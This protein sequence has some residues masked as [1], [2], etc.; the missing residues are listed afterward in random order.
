M[1][2]FQSSGKQ[3]IDVADL[4]EMYKK[5]VVQYPS[6]ALYLHEFKG[7]CRVLDT[8]EE[9][10][11]M[12]NIFKTFD[13]NGDNVID[14]LEYVAALNLVLRGKLEHKL[15]WSF[16][17]YD[18]DGNG[19][20]DKEELREII[21]VIYNI[22]TGSKLDHE[23]QL[24]TPDEVCDRIFKIVDVNGD[25]AQ[26]IPCGSGIRE[27]SQAL[28][29]APD[30]QEGMNH[31]SMADAS[32]QLAQTEQL[33]VQLKELI[34]EKDH[35]LRTKDEQIK[36]EKEACEAKLSKVKLQN[37]AKVNSLN[38]QLEE[39]KKQLTPSGT[40]EERA[41]LK[42]ATGDGN[43]E[44]A[45]ASRGKILL[46]KKKVEE[47]ETQLS[48][49]KAE[50]KNK[51]A[52]IET[53]R[54]R[55]FEIDAMLAEKDKKLSEKEAYIIDLQLIASGE[56]PA[57]ALSTH[58]E[59]P[60]VQLTEKEIPLQDLQMLVKN[61]TKKVEESEEKYSLLKEQSESL[62]ELLVTE[63]KQFEGKENMYKENIQTFKDIIME[64]E[65]NLVEQYQK[66]EHELFKLAAKSD[67]SA[68]LEQ[69]LKALKQKLHEKEEVL[70]G[71]TQVVDVLQTEL[72]TRDQQIKE[73]SEKM[74]R[75]Q[76]EKDSMQ[77]K[78]DAEKHVM[79]AQL[80]D[81][82]QKHE[83]ELKHVREKHETELSE[84]DQAYLQLQKQL[85]EVRNHTEAAGALAMDSAVDA[86]SNPRIVALEVQAKL[87]TEEAS[88]SEAKFLKMK[89]WSKSRI[90]QL[91]DE[92]KKAQSGTTSSDITALR[93]RLVE[94]EDEREE[95][96]QK[97]EQYEELKTLNA[98][99]V[100]KL[101]IYE[102]QQRKMQADL[103]Q[104]TKRAASRTSESGS[105]DELQ[106]HVLKWQD[107]VSDAEGV[108]DQAREE[109][110]AM[111]LR[112]THLEEEREVLVTRQQELEEELAQA[113]GL[114]AKRGKQKQ[115]ANITH[116]LQEDFEFD[117]KQSYQ[118]PNNTLDSSD[119]A[120]G[121]NMGGLRSVVEE[122]ELERNQLQEQILTL[123]EQCQHL[124]DRLQ[125][126]AR[127]ES[128]Q[129]EN[130]RL[131]GQLTNLRSQ[132]SRDTEKHQVLISSLNQ[133]LKGFSDR[134]EILESSLIEKEQT[135]METSEKLEQI[136][137][138]RDSLKEK[139]V[140]N[141]E[142]NDKL[143]QAE[144]NVS[145]VTGKC[146]TYEKQCS[147]LKTSVADLTHRLNTAKEK[148]QK[149]DVAI[150][151]LQRDLDQ[152]NDEL[153]KLN[154]S[155]LEERAQ[156]IH[157]LQSCERE[158][159]SLKDVLLQKDK[160][161]TAL[162]NSMTEY[163]DQVLQL[164]QQMK[165][166][167]EEM[168]GM[169]TALAKVERQAQIIR[170]SQS[171]DEQTMNTKLASLV[172]QL[173]EME[174]EL[175]NTREENKAKCSEVEE[176]V[177]QVHDDNGI[178]QN[179]RTDIQKLKHIMIWKDLFSDRE[180]IL[181]SSLIEKEQTLMETSEKLEQIENIRDSLKEKEVQNKELND[182]LLQAEQNVS[183]VTGKCC[184]YEKQC[185]ELKTSVADLTHR[186]NTAKEKTQKQDVAIEIL[187]RDLD[188]TN[189]ELDKLNSS[190]L[191]ERAQL[192]HDLQSC[193]REIDSLKDVLLQ[194]DKEITALSN[195]MTEYLD[196]VLQLKQQMK[197][198][199][200]EMVGMETAL[201]KVERQAQIIR[202]SQSSDE[203]TMNTKLA[204]LVEQ[205]KEMEMELS[206]TR[207]ENKAKCS[208]VEELVK[209]VHDD[210]GIIQNLRTDIQKLNVT[211]RTHLAECETQLSSLKEQVT[212]SSRRLQEVDA[213]SLEETN[214]LAA[215]LEETNTAYK[216]LENM[217]Q[218]KEQSFET[219]L[220]SF[221]DEC[222]KLIAEVTRKDEEL[223]IFSKQLAEHVEHQ[224]TGKRAVH[225]KLETISCLEGKL[226]ATQQE[227]E[228]TKLKLNQK[229]Q[230]KETECIQLKEQ[231]EVKS[232]S[233][234]KLETEVKT[235]E[236]KNE[237]LQTIVQKKDNEILVQTNLA[238][239]LNEKVANVQGAN[240]NLQCK[241][242]QLTDESEKLKRKLTDQ[243]SLQSKQHDLVSELQG[244]IS[245]NEV[246]ISEYQ[247]TVAVMQ[248]EKEEL[249][250]KTEDLVK[251]LEQNQNVVAENLVDKTSECNNLAKLLSEN[252]ESIAHLQD[253]VQ[254]LTSQID[255]LKC[256]IAE[257]EQAV[258]DRVNTCENLQSQLG[259]LQETLPMLQEQNHA[260]QLGLVEK[261]LILQEKV[262]ECHSLQKQINQQ[263]ES[264][265]NLQ[266]EVDSLK[267]EGKKLTQ[268]L[269]E[270]E[271]AFQS[272]ICECNELFDQIQS[273]NEAIAV[274]SRQIDVMNEESVKL[275]SEN[276]DLKTTLNNRNVDYSK[277]HE[278]ATLSKT[279]AAE[280]QSQVQILNAEIQDTKTDILGKLNE[281][282]VLQSELSKK[283][284]TIVLLNKQLQTKYVEQ[285]GQLSENMAVIAQLQTQGQDMQKAL[286]QKENTLNMQ[287]K[288]IKQLKDKAEESEMLKSQL[289]EYLEMISDLQ[290]QLKSMTER[291]D[292]LKCSMTEK[293]AVLKKK[294]DD[295][296]SLKAQFCD[297]E[298]TASQL[299]VQ[300]EQV[301]TELHTVKDT[302]KE[303][304]LNLKQIEESSLVQRE[305]LI[306]KY[307]DK[308][309]EC[310]SLKDELSALQETASGLN[311]HITTQSS[312]INQLK[313][314]VLKTETGI[315]E[316]NK[317]MQELQEQVEEAKLFKSQLMESTELI[318]QLQR[319]LQK[320]TSES[321]MLDKSA[322]EKQTAFF[323]LQERYAAQTEQ[324]QEIKSALAQKNEEISSL[325]R[326][327][328]EKG[329]I[330]KVAEN[331]SSTLKIEV[332]QLKVEL[333]KNKVSY[334]DLQQKENALAAEI[335][336]QKA[337]NLEAVKQLNIAN[338]AVEQ[339]ELVV[340]SLNSKYAEQLQNIERLNSEIL[341]LNE[342]NSDMKKEM[343]LMAQ[344]LQQKLDSAVREKLVLKQDI[345]RTI[346]EKEELIKNYSDQLQKKKDE[347]QTL[348]QLVANLNEA[349]ERLKNEK[350][351]LQMQV[352]AKGEE[353]TG[354]K[355]EIQKIEQTLMDSENEWLADL[356]RDNQKSSLLTEQLRSL[357]NEMNSKD[358]KIQA[359]QQDLDNMQGKF[360]E[361][362]SALKMSSDE[363]TEKNM[364][365]AD[366]SQHIT[367]NQNKLE[368]MCL[369]V[370][371]KD[372]VVQH[373]LSEREKE[374]KNLQTE[375]LTSQHDLSEISQS[376]SEKLLAFEEEKFT[377]Q[378]AMKQ[379]K[380]RHQSEVESLKQELDRNT[381]VL[382]QK[383]SEMSEKDK[384][385]Q[386]EKKQVRLLQQQVMNLQQELAIS[387]DKLSSIVNDVHIKE[388]Q[389]QSLTLQVNQ[390][391]E[392]LTSINQ[393]LREKNLSVTRVMES[394][395]NEIVK[396]TE[397]KNQLIVQIENLE[398]KHSCSTKEIESLYQQLDEYKSTLSHS[399]A[400]VQ[401]K[402]VEKQ[403][404]INE[405]E[406]L[407]VHHDKLAKEKDIMKR[408]F[409][410]ALLVRKELMKKIEELEKKSQDDLNKDKETANL[411]N[412]VQ[413]LTSQVTQAQTRCKEQ[414]S[415]L[416][417]LK[418]QILQKEADINEFVQSLST[419]ET[420]VGQ[421]ED[422]IQRLETT[423]LERETSLADALKA[424]MEKD[425]VIEA[426]QCSSKE[427]EKFFHNERCELTSMLGQLRDELLKKEEPIKV[428][429]TIP[430][431]TVVDQ[432]SNLEAATQN[433]K[434]LEQEKE[435]LQKKLHAALLAR[436]EAIKKAQEKERNLRAE[437]IQQKEEFD[438]L[439]T[440]FSQQAEELKTTKEKLTT[441]QQDYCGKL[442]EFENN[443]QVIGALQ[444][445]LN[446]INAH[447]EEKEKSLQEVKMQLEE[448][449][450][451][452][453]SA[454]HDQ[455]IKMS[456]VTSELE[457]KANSQKALED[458]S[459][460]LAR[461]IEQLRSEI[462]RANI[463]ITE[464]TEELLSLQRTV[465]IAQQ[466]HQ[467]EKQVLIDECTELQNQLTKTQSDVEY[468][469]ISLE[470]IKKEK[471]SQSEAFNNSNKVLLEANNELKEELEKVH[472]LI[473]EKSD[474]CKAMKNTLA[475]MQ[476]QFE[477]EKMGIKAKSEQM[478]SCW[479][480]AQAKA[481]SYKLHLEKIEKEKEDIFCSLEKSRGVSVTLQEQLDKSNR[482]KE[483]LAEK[484]YLLQEEISAATQHEEKVF[485]LQ[486][487]NEKLQ[488]ILEEKENAIVSLKSSISE[489]EE[490]LAALELQMQKALHLHE[491]ERG[492]VKTEMHELHQKA[493][494][495]S[496]VSKEQSDVSKSNEQITR[497]LQAALISRKEALK[498][499]K[500]LKD[501]IQTLYSEKEELIRM[502]SSLE[503]SL[504]DMKNQ[505]EDLKVSIAAISDEKEILISE[506]DKILSDNHSL[507]AACESLKHTIENITQQKQAFS[508]QLESLKDSE[509]EEL[510]EWKSKHKE[511]KQEYES[512]LQA[513]ENISSEMDKMRQL[514]ET[515]RK[516]K[517]EVLSKRCNL[518][519]EKEVLEKQLNEAEEEQEKQKEKMRT[520]AKL[521]QQ[522]IQ[523]LEEENG[524][525]KNDQ[526]EM[527]EKQQ[528][529]VEELAVKKI[530]LEEENKE[531]QETCE[532]LRVKLN[533]IQSEKSSLLS[534]VEA[535]RSSLEKLQAET[536]ASQSDLQIK[537]N[538]ALSLKD[539]LAAELES[540]KAD[541][542]AKVEVIKTLEQE[543]LSL[544]EQVTELERQHKVELNKRDNTLA[545]LDS[546]INSNLR[547][548]ISL[549]EKVRI[550][551]DDKS[552]LQ[553]ELENVQEISEK[554]KNENEYLET[555][556]LKSAERIDLLTD[557]VNTLQ[558]QNNLLSTQLSEIK[559]EKYGLIREKEGQQVKLVRDF[560]E[561]LKVA[562]RG[563]EGSKSVT[564]ELQEL[565]REKHQEINQMQKDCIQYQELI[566]DLERSVKLSQSERDA[567][568]KEL[569]NV[570][571]KV[572]K[573]D[574]EI[575][576]LYNEITSYKDLLS[577]ARKQSERV[578]SENARLKEELVQKEAQA[579]LQ[580]MDRKKELEQVNEQQ[581]A[582]YKNE[583]MKV[584]ERINVLQREKERNREEVLQLKSE[585]ESRDLLT[586]ILEKEA[587]T[588]LAKLAAFSRTISSLQNDGDSVADETKQW[589]L[590]FQEVIEDKEKQLLDQKL[591]VL[592][593]TE[594]MKIKD[595]QIHEFQHKSSKLEVAFDETDSRYKA[596]YVDFQNEKTLLIATSRELSR[597]F[598]MLKER[599]EEQRDHVQ[600][601]EE[602]KKVLQHQL[603]DTG[604]A[605]VQMKAELLT[606]EKRFTD[607]D[608]ELQLIQSLSD[609]L[610]VDL[611]KQEAISMQLKSLLINKDTE[612]SML[613]SSK[614]GEISG[615]LA[616]IQNQNRIQIASYEERVNALYDDKEKTDKAFRGLENRIK[617]LQVKYEKSVQEKEQMAAKMGNLKNAL[618]SSQSERDGLL[619]EYKVLEE[620]YRSVA[621]EK[622]ILIQEKATE[623]K[624]L[625][626]EM[627]TL[628]HQMDDLNSENAML[629]A[630][631]IRY[632]EDLNQVLSLKDNQL[633]Q[634]LKKQ[635]D[636]IKNLEHGTAVVEKQYR[637]A[638][639][640]LE[641][642]IETIKSLE[643]E[644][645][646]LG[647][648]VCELEAVI[649]TMTKEKLEMNET[650][651]IADLQE[652]IAAKTTEC[653]ELKQ[654]LDAQKATTKELKIKVKKI[655]KDTDKIL[656][657]AEVKYNKELAAFEQDVDL[658]RNV[659]ERA[660]E[661]VVEISKDLM[662]A[663]QTIS[664]A[665]NLNK[666][667]K[668]QNESFG[669]AMAALQNDRDKLIEDFKHMQMKYEDELKT[670]SDKLN[671]LELQL[672]DATS[673]LNALVKER[674]VLIRTLSAFESDSTYNQLMVQIEDLRKAVA[675]RDIEIT[676]FSSEKETYSRQMTAFSKS[677]ASLQDDRDRLL[678]E[679]RGSKRVY[680]PR[681][682]TVSAASTVDSATDL[683][684]CAA[685]QAENNRLSYQIQIEHL[686]EQTISEAK[687][688]NKELK[689]Q[690]ESFGKAMAAL[691]NDRDKLI[692]DFKHM[693]MK[694][695]D[696]LKTSSDK[697][698]KLEL[699]LNDATSE[700]NALVKERTVLIRTLSAFE[701]DSTYNQ[702][703]VQIEDLR[704]A[705]ADRDIEIT[706]FSSEKET[707]SRQM[708]AFSKS[709]ASLQDDRDRLLQELR[710]S[711]RVYEPRQGTVSAASTV[712]SATDLNNCAALQAENNRL[713][714]EI[715]SLRSECM[716]LPQMKSKAAEL[717]KA[718]QQA[719]AFRLQTEQDVGAYQTELAELRTEKNL[720]L[721]ESRSLKEQYLIMVADKDRQISELQKLYPE[722]SRKSSGIYPIKTESVTLVANEDS[723]DQVKLLL[724]ERIQLQSD[725]QRCLQEIHHRDLCFQQLN[726]KMMQTIEEK[727]NLT[728]QLKAVAQTLRD[729]QLHHNELQNR[730]YWLERQLQS[731]PI[732]ASVQGHVQ[733]K[734]GALSVKRWLRGRSLY[735]SKLLTSRAKSRYLFLTY[736]LALHFAVFMCLTGIL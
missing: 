466:Q 227:A 142:L 687:N 136:E 413:E 493:A 515:T 551:E 580:K 120:D 246:H 457:N 282:A 507:S 706:R 530:E 684:N 509:T 473:A 591:A 123:E 586:K 446:Y 430:L 672:N 370:Q 513:Y 432:E 304:E 556:L 146:C 148:T 32:E 421:L 640:G 108:R 6:G 474:D 694:Y 38:S 138:I 159:D 389:I 299:R 26:L 145:E 595:M 137:N 596:A 659:S 555:V 157:D 540:Q 698:N 539:L 498:E 612:I 167:E 65:N 179:L 104:V 321:T 481:E 331:T 155:H 97:L 348:E 362:S 291:S 576:N 61:L 614:G 198:K 503:K 495:M 714:Q 545:K 440:E 404:L 128:L 414:D 135:L 121:E 349:G 514:V 74:K 83:T 106:S 392:L 258:I 529:T 170:E 67:A 736:L 563:N 226:K 639:C 708:T 508:C 666:E 162:S 537:I 201:A 604:D 330:I 549:N 103:E 335:E 200:E 374:I 686:A 476:H 35:I 23:T 149:Q 247:K 95:I 648:Q 264:V 388:G 183:E 88:K 16:K 3:E 186:L 105:A 236:N 154:S 315:L 471:D 18:K 630:Q 11:Y 497:K 486:S 114:R 641:Q 351:Q 363:L 221:K 116:N 425:A 382:Q 653:N 5:F 231:L 518:E 80:R 30:S 649:T 560:E 20:L 411:Q 625:K 93:N 239:D 656:S 48:Q 469:T 651:V 505:Q 526:L 424:G 215:Q 557:T 547:E 345:D 728:T 448:Q 723:S 468:F 735:C 593:L 165:Y 662:Q 99:L 109:K 25:G 643:S 260:L 461:E 302:V 285:E 19:C 352:S 68:E 682:G 692:E 205:L 50:L 677:M 339:R 21:E 705:V 417:L 318:Y 98:E 34:R 251:L 244:K 693:Q 256:N 27:T 265:V 188:Q 565:L 405:K 178:I 8:S 284:D 262:T 654:N 689:S 412:T 153:D 371:K 517:Q 721:T 605:V 276:E 676:R 429:E 568:E 550:L 309:D 313:E 645:E 86:G 364:V 695:E 203:Q 384:Y 587:N 45:A 415:H 171:S 111:A 660:E 658:M 385:I 92:L 427:N 72:N 378:A 125:L 365:V 176:L 502:S 433:L 311:E 192:I 102:E 579:D 383:V 621:N 175:S 33:V 163:L 458:D 569:K 435:L 523:E 444:S 127:I 465:N 245:A 55:G 431:S 69:L 730:C 401:S 483:E 172:E 629:K 206:N 376:M 381:E 51:N 173:K 219:E 272:R 623:S 716:E 450:N 482:L 675:D 168:V 292:H 287:Q 709:M 702:L 664:E 29:K 320:L 602:D 110:A 235:L 1:G 609:T 343:K 524:K 650:K 240:Q 633:K 408:K 420:L 665:K 336:V 278:Q 317:A 724:T 79:R 353:I 290:K 622:A 571:E 140:Q 187:Q 270:K 41:G 4:Q 534:D 308:Q 715:T 400:L 229:L 53:Q 242:N 717:Q 627:K 491:V 24:L 451:K 322:E 484:V 212:A 668:S 63:K 346:A 377:L 564:K 341:S 307:K 56:N 601:L 663:E 406:Q 732:Q 84:K 191:E 594:E 578:Q 334:A 671:K 156:L 608:S 82:M 356:D 590:K 293:E 402:D 180:E 372:S 325:H 492:R 528:Q 324:L 151:I 124:E 436:R 619:S 719:D 70:L 635:L 255:Q 644:N 373:I 463:K 700:L 541:I 399:Q 456:A 254:L 442:K 310:E 670:S 312:E 679:L 423:I 657:D 607:T 397:E 81:L 126:Q 177:K 519:T 439:L 338:Q 646:K 585:I 443:Q 39:L 357:E 129:N 626:Q 12:D 134:E 2:Q 588:N 566:L 36:M 637:D 726:G 283:E 75:L 725:L 37:K 64:K 600:K 647:I 329:D 438:K 241:V 669:K 452:M 355:L 234:L 516:E 158:I 688:L 266:N 218:K 499:N 90:K 562:Q 462:E 274:L 141:K 696:E 225:E 403:G 628:L 196:Q 316:Q 213:K 169:E 268:S 611:E 344:N 487:Q 642:K 132:H 390:Q 66:H 354:L 298:D 369:V 49:Y 577:E 512:L 281:I 209:Q 62:K 279:E 488:V 532:K 464:K 46:L 210:N 286:Q 379:L 47:L 703:M 489:K 680:E 731:R 263:N 133:Q 620:R 314:T 342:K 222:N 323:H 184:T 328:S 208:E 194:K 567:I 259:Q 416:E 729:T 296:V 699:Q 552:L 504:A 422:N 707:Y 734:G 350:E 570:N 613:L 223:L 117:G 426:L 204:S 542:V 237:Q 618:T 13:K 261:D 661:R 445:Q 152:T 441:I 367:E 544:S 360:A 197:Y 101:Q 573:F 543:K 395:S 60:K 467:Q 500:S 269:E 303:K 407:K 289:N 333:V 490:L 574:D 527:A 419:K 674:T 632:R 28:P 211:H 636:S 277:L 267:D 506:V 581:K 40:K 711:K 174:M 631:L 480:Q 459:K 691:Q 485:L 624:T 667:L 521:K 15:K 358:V 10:L 479:K 434:E 301:T 603:S 71:R 361:V 548:T 494:D 122:L 202:E 386:D 652:K 727:T 294:V 599:F 319:Q 275:K 139:E 91:E 584:E 199:E 697:L 710:G 295:Y 144:Q 119:F 22:K 7:F 112:M 638:V 87:K 673:E 43:Q 54:Q 243:E 472:S 42:K 475:E 73:L 477:L 332:E 572:S 300:L 582:L 340:Q 58:A 525:I 558:V 681:Q 380:L 52:E 150:E 496:H 181:E 224:A 359:L 393:Q 418:Q 575:G 449:E 115:A 510:S 535:T 615:Y 297:L 409:Q 366:L 410:A 453:R 230:V 193:E 617:N 233:I 248:K 85:E 718:L 347:L 89:A 437:S 280:L 398:R 701:S 160:E 161:I 722:E 533:E 720:L 31:K 337:Q 214:K 685:L 592:H 327:I 428:E 470:D 257:K 76:V 17:V 118:D 326:L 96:L 704:K 454:L 589:E 368:E 391:K 712:D 195:S 733:M 238:A 375:K 113:R 249:T 396:H 460:E 78:L 166:K 655:E 683:N 616:E 455:E 220:K 216:N 634:L 559:E 94:L 546:E 273:N 306:L 305:D 164:K 288:E 185:S 44:H 394:A 59:A 478:E 553:E 147:E 271:V 182:K 511:L 207:E 610:Q 678:Q 531:L 190:H 77:S 9:S 538:E 131:Q 387:T 189:D 130:E 14:F 520:F 250:S 713:L 217:L 597:N 583:L 252:Q 501:K 522:E 57:R 228:E 100:A 606:L 690:N 253:Q 447:L 561:K 107:M 598:E 232:E 143:L 536:K 554:V